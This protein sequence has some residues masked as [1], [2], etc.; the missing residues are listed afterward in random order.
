MKVDQGSDFVLALELTRDGAAMTN[1]TGY[2]IRGQIRSTFTSTTS[3]SF[4]GEAVDDTLG[5]FRI[6]LT[7]AVTAAMTAGV[8]VYDVELYTGSYVTRILQGT[9]TLLPEVTR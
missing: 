9:L 5:H 1:L 4:V 3:V 7:A 6:S 8:Y 2:N